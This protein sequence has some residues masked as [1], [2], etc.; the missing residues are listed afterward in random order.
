VSKPR[1]ARPA[2]L[3]R[4]EVTKLTQMIL[5]YFADAVAFDPIVTD[6]FRDRVVGQCSAR[7][8]ARL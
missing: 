5:A 3:L 4:I 2:I 6:P 7:E 1:Y 8:A